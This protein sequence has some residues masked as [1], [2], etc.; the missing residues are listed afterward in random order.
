MT[1]RMKNLGWLGLTVLLLAAACGDDAEA[2]PP[3]ASA[4]A[5]KGGKGGKGGSGGRAGS[6]GTGGSVGEADDAGQSPADAG[7]DSG[8]SCEGDKGCY[9]CEAKEPAQFLNHC[10]DSQCE[11]FDNEKRLPLYNHG[12]LPQLP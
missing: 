10:T 3:D 8:T 12:D 6:G 4:E 11:A 2:T 9:S 1:Y 5:G 7:K